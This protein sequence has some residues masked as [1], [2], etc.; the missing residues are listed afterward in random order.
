MMAL[1]THETQQVLT[2]RD[3]DHHHVGYCISYD[4]IKPTHAAISTPKESISSICV[5]YE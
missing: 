1:H 3:D 2:D 4:Y 5:Q